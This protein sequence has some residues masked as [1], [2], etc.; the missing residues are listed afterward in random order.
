MTFLIQSFVFT[1]MFVFSMLG[2]GASCGKA[3]AITHVISLTCL[4]T[5]HGACEDYKP[6]A[7]PC[8]HGGGGKDRFVPSSQVDLV[9]EKANVF[10]RWAGH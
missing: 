8:A 4:W 2:N 6:R 3:F 7:L 5:I 10:T 1:P 9:K